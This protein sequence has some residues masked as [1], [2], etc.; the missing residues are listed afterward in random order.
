MP[1][2]AQHDN[3]ESLS[4][5]MKYQGYPNPRRATDLA[6]QILSLKEPERER[7]EDKSV[8]GNTK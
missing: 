8:Q 5:A 3:Q 1:R 7:Q 4:E 2:G 6:T